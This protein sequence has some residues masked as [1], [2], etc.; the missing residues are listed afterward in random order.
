MALE[1]EV[2]RLVV[3]LVGDASSYQQ[4][5]AQAQV[6]TKVAAQHVEAAATRV[7]GFGLGMRRFALQA[8]GALGPLTGILSG[9]A[10][11]FRGVQLAASAE[12]ME[13]SFGTMLRSAE[14]GQQLVKDLQTFAAATPLDLET[15]QAA[16]KTLLQFGVAGDKLL[17]T[18]RMI[19][20]ATG[21]EAFRVQQMA[22]AFGQM[23]SAGRLMGQDLL[24]MIN[25][26]F[27]PL[28]EIS[29]TTGKSMAVL[30][31]E[32]ERGR[33]T[34]QMVEGAFRSA[35]G[36]GGQFAGLM[37]KQS[38]SLS[39]LFSTMRDDI[40]AL[41]RTVGQSIVEFLRLKEV[42]QLVSAAAQEATRWVQSLSPEMKRL[43]AILVAA[44]SAA[45]AFSLVWPIIKSV[46]SGALTTLLSGIDTLL[47]PINLLGVLAGTVLAAW[48]SGVG[49]LGPAWEIVRAAAVRAW[50]WLGPVREALGQLFAAV[51]DTAVQAFGGL[52]DFVMGVW[53]SINLSAAVNWE[54]VRDTVRDVI[55][56]LT[57]L[58]RNLGS[59]LRSLGDV[60][61]SVWGVIRDGALKVWEA[62][63][64]VFALTVEWLDDFVRR[65][66]DA[67]RTVGLLT[68]GV[69]AAWTAYK[70]LAF[71]IG[72]VG[73]ALA[74]LG[75]KQVLSTALWVAWKLVVLT[76]NAAIAAT[77]LVLG[78]L[79][80]VG[81]LP[82]LAAVG[83]LVTAFGA[84]SAAL[85]GIVSI[86]GAVVGFLGNMATAAGPV[87]HIGALLGEWVEIFKDVVR[88]VRVDM[89]LAWQFIQTGFRL[90]ISQVQ[91]LWPPLW[92][93]IKEGFAILFVLVRE[94]AKQ[95]LAD[96]GR[97]ARHAARD[98][99]GHFNLDAVFG[100]Q[101]HNKDQ[102]RKN[103]EELARI[104]EDARKQQIGLAEARLDRLIKNFKV[105]GSAV[106]DDIRKELEGLRA[107]LAAA[108]GKAREVPPV[109]GT[110][111]ATQAAARQ[112]GEALATNLVG[113]AKQEL[114]SLD[115]V[116]SRSV[117]AF[118]RLEEHRA[119]LAVGRPVPPVAGS[120]AGGL[121][122]FFGNLARQATSSSVPYYNPFLSRPRGQ[123]PG[124]T[125]EPTR[126]S[127]RL[128]GPDA[129]EAEQD[130]GLVVTLLKEI[131]DQLRKTGQQ[132]PVV[133]EDLALS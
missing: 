40:D 1:H 13:I 128:V 124:E 59:I 83:L 107:Q 127:V 54:A 92:Q 51:R 22:L 47:G 45:T 122:G 114:K 38:K 78:L 101:T 57:V 20:D 108:E 25:A 37:E 67:V 80:S 95:A 77:T 3:R 100:G 61:L 14:A 56:V 58:V 110:D 79:T 102:A 60:A 63:K 81:L 112:A 55:L 121:G 97:G 130:R 23:A 84:I 73:A 129:G 36:P 32:M 82:A 71:G 6:S 26:G 85:A 75:I 39:G 104:S 86:G 120:V 7:E 93:F 2:E 111:P 113:P 27:N 34:L 68:A 91:S 41:L 89:P 99:L 28:Q 46:G 109:P 94:L 119:R 76:V 125:G 96:V 16:S 133:L 5:L 44:T 103:A 18:L 19:G 65:N 33:I 123:R 88:A 9:L 49:G 98:F 53:T 42:V 126:F 50:D 11:A 117:A 12:Q 21:G 10:G 70:L 48:V 15:L 116:L 35:T 29:R 105:E 24:Q 131:R 52:R 72:L 106:T 43:V 74:L 132:V 90:V 118:T 87:Q 115:A 30:R 62:V 17:P 31:Q 8:I 64:Q 69:L 66:R 4:M